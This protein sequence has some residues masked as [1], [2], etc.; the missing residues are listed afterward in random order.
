MAVSMHQKI[1]IWSKVS[2][3]F[4]PNPKGI[5]LCKIPKKLRTTDL[6]ENFR[7]PRARDSSE[8]CTGGYT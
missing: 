3:T 1:N 8:L 7:S 4:P 5:Y 2:G 6:N